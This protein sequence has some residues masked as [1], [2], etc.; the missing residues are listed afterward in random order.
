M[1]PDQ[2]LVL[3]YLGYSWL[4]KGLRFDEALEMIRKAVEQRPEDGYIVDS[5]GW[6]HY[7]MDDFPA[8]VRELERAVELRPVDPVINDHFGDALWRVGRRL[9]AEFQWRRAMSFDPEEKDLKRIK[10][11]LEVGL[12]KVLAEEAAAD[13][14]AATARD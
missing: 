2:P 12:D 8:A 7:L 4:E 1:R 14:P 5:L 6:A 10:R 9:E 3:N 11:K 13:A